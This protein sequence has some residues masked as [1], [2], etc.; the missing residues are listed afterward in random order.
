VW[1]PPHFWALAMV[2]Q[3]DYAKVGVPMLP[4]IAGD[5][6][7]AKQIWAYTLVLV[8]ITLLMTL[9]W[10]RPDR[11]TWPLLWDWGCYL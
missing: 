5:E 4:V 6:A 2:I 8:P 3:D 11:S 7:T 9:P 1:T 10:G